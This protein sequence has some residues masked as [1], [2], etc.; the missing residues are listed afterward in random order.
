VGLVGV[1]A[2]SRTMAIRRLI[3][4]RNTALKPALRIVLAPIGDAHADVVVRA[5]APA[6]GERVVRVDPR[7]RNPHYYLLHEL[8]HLEH[9]GWSETTVR[10]ETA[11]RWRRMGWRDKAKL[12]LLLGRARLSA[13]SE[14]E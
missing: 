4:H 7:S 6:A 1:E 14:P 10:R 2:A 13:S 5:G 3:T 12:L 9:V 11:R 8:I